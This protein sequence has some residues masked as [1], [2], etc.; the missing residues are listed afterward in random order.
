MPLIPFVQSQKIER[1]LAVCKR[2][3]CK[4]SSILDIKDNYTAFCFDEACLYIMAR[5]E[6]NDI[7]KYIEQRTKEEGNESQ[8]HYSSFKEYYKKVMGG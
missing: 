7:P 1:V 4:P 8:P 3:G 2:Y 5:L 6:N